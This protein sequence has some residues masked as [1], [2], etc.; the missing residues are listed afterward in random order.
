L[1]E[2]LVKSFSDLTNT[3]IELGN[4]LMSLPS[5]KRESFR[6]VVDETYQV[7]NT[8]IVIVI[9]RLGKIIEIGNNH[10][11]LKRQLTGLNNAEEW[12]EIHQKV[13]TCNLLRAIRKEMD[14]LRASVTNKLSG[15]SVKELKILMD[16]ALREE[17]QLGIYINNHIKQMA[18]LA[19]AVV[20]G[21]NKAILDSVKSVR[22]KLKA[23]QMRLM[24]EHIKFYDLIYPKK[25]PSLL[26]RGLARLR[27]LFKRG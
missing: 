16:V 27:G 4:S 21:E 20:P 17:K 9:N 3:A 2:E 18:Q 7:I 14:S 24:D 12:E 10:Q 11:E 15:S 6:N 22:E 8:A 1:S 23:E 26:S 25:K 13:Y 5:E 19:D